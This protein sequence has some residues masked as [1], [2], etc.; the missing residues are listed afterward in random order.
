MYYNERIKFIRQ[1][2]NI[3][4]L[5]MAERLGIKQTNYSQYERGLHEPSASRLKE[6]CEILNVSA[7]Y[8]LGLPRN[9]E[10]PTIG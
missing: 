4:Q 10:H 8:I 5:E 1:S 9:L 7:D 6:I 2:K 3:T